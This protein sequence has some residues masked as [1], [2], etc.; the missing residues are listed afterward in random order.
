MR[1]RAGSGKVYGNVVHRILERLSFGGPAGPT[2][3]DGSALAS[4]VTRELRLGGQTEAAGLDLAQALPMIVRAPIDAPE[5]GT[6]AALPPGFSLG[7][8]R[9]AD[10]Q[11][12]LRFHL[13]LGDGTAFVAGAGG[14]GPSTRRIV[15]LFEAH[16]AELPRA[17]VNDLARAFRDRGGSDALRGLLTGS[18][19]LVFRVADPHVAG[20]HRYFLADYKTNRLGHDGDEET[21]AAYVRPRLADAMAAHDYHLQSLLYTVAL[22]RELGLRLPAYRYDEH[23]GGSLYLFVRGMSSGVRWTGAPHP[24]VY[25]QRFSE[26]LIRELDELL[27][28][29]HPGEST[30]VV[31][32]P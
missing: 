6:E 31:P 1:L 20:G 17:W 15:A 32:C 26:A 4:L 22:H 19:D 28:P 7:S 18:I 21:V 29:P 16:S 24:G 2:P 30:R 12:E 10:R 8:I 9:D 5:L 13:A 23:F 25:A 27:T 14:D 11:D 3:R